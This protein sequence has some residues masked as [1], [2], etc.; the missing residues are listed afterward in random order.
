M[1]M[2]GRLPGEHVSV[3]QSVKGLAVASDSA[4]SIVA[5]GSDECSFYP[6]IRC[7]R[8]LRTV[9]PVRPLS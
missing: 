4:R 2:K 1:I 8:E 5:T 3:P 7:P 6:G 9:P